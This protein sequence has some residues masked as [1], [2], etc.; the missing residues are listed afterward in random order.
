LLKKILPRVI[1]SGL[2]NHNNRR[3]Q[4]NKEPVKKSIMLIVLT[5]AVTLQYIA[6]LGFFLHNSHTRLAFVRYQ[7]LGHT[8]AG[9]IHSP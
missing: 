7:N 8:D 2:P 9:E 5:V 4:T 1:L 6:V 3:L